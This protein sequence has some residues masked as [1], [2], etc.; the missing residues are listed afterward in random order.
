MPESGEITDA[1]LLK[2]VLACAPVRVAAFDRSGR[3]LLDPDPNPPVTTDAGTPPGASFLDLYGDI[4]GA[5]DAVLAAL[6]GNETHVTRQL[7]GATY[8]GAFLPRRD[9]S[10]EVHAVL[11]VATVI[12]EGSEVARALAEVQL[13]ERRVFDSTMIGLLYWDASGAVTDA[14]AAFLAIVGYNREDLDQGKLDWQAMTP[15][16]YREA[17][18][19]ALSEVREHGSCSPY[20]KE[21]VRKDGSRVE[22]LIGGASW[23]PG[24]AAG[25]AF[26]VDITERKRAE[27]VRRDAEER[28]RRVVDA[29]PIV[30]W[31]VDTAGIFTLSTGRGLAALGLRPGQVVGQSAYELYADTP[32]IAR[33]IRRCL[34]G[35]EFIE[36]V[37]VGGLVFE[38]RYTPLRDATAPSPACS[39]SRWT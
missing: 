36:Q 1:D 9:A 11:A 22:I 28:L 33:A 25:V 2:V 34:A 23:A 35:E 32:A 39:G 29:A 24:N 15:P 21:Y 4:P 27:R 17:D 12:Q 6:A 26:V 31:S 5:H 37:E 20:E 18:E 10:G 19:R 14:N 16:E 30:L 13:R 3:F 7:G 8:V 38:N